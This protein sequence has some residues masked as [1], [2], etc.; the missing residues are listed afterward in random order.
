MQWLNNKIT[1]LFFLYLSGGI[2]SCPVE[3]HTHT[4]R[5]EKRNLDMGD[6]IFVCVRVCESVG[7][8][9]CVSRASGSNPQPVRS[10]LSF[11]FR[12]FL[13]IFLFVLFFVVFARFFLHV[14]TLQVIFIIIIHFDP[15]PPSKI[16]GRSLP[17]IYLNF[18]QKLCPQPPPPLH[19]HTVKK[20][21]GELDVFGYS[22]YVV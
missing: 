4:G 17:F 10:H 7:P 1:F 12:L 16:I 11:S 15:T 19:S 9:G 18:Y 20:I 8:I 2:F 13:F 22:F 5:N 3:T 21:S 6:F 14:E